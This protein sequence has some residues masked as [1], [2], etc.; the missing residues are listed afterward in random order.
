[1]VFD[2]E[3]VIEDFAKYLMTHWFRLKVINY[4]SIKS[5]INY[6]LSC[7]SCALLNVFAVK[8]RHQ[9]AAIDG[10]TSGFKINKPFDLTRVCRLKCDNSIDDRISGFGLFLSWSSDVNIVNIVSRSQGQS[11][12]SARS[13]FLTDSCL[14]EKADTS[15][16]TGCEG[17]RGSSCEYCYLEVKHLFRIGISVQDLLYA[18]FEFST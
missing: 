9:S 13:F 18:T 1:L 7:L 2:G 6:R 15:I 3:V 4:C 12:C 17:L 10:I 16:E 14:V 11:H 5:H 8:D